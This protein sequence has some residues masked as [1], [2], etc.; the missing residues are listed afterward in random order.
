MVRT[1]RSGRGG[2]T[3]DGTDDGEESGSLPNARPGARVPGGAGDPLAPGGS[4][5]D[6]PGMPTNREHL[7]R[8]TALADANADEVVRLVTDLDATRL[9]WRPSPER[10]GIADCLEH[11]L[12]TG[13]AYYPKL[14]TAIC[15][16][17][18]DDARE[19]AP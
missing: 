11:L 18:H 6:P 16:A 1:R 3:D 17:P 13:A 2:M 14:R 15:D 9:L 5:V 4:T 10:W 19:G 8:L 12:A 7:E